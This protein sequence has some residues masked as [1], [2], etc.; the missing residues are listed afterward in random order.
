[1][2][3]FMP[4]STGVDM[5]CVDLIRN[6]VVSQFQ[7]ENGEQEQAYRD[8]WVPMES[9]FIAHTQAH[10]TKSVCAHH[11]GSNL[12]ADIKEGDETARQSTN[13]LISIFAAGIADFLVQS[14]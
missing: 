5:S 2:V 13:T 6:T 10:L 1:M 9:S 14:G 3:F 11:D 8:L 4:K 12:S 7:T